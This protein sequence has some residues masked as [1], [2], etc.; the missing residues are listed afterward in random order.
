[1]DFERAVRCSQVYRFLSDCFRY[2][3]ED[4]LKDIELLKPIV[5]ELGFSFPD[6]DTQSWDT[7][8]LQ[9][10]HRRIF[11]L[12]G[13]LCYETEYGLPHEFRQSQE[14]A[15]ISGFYK[16]FGLKPGGK[17]RE[18]PDHLVVELE[19]MYLLCLKEALAHS[20]GNR[21]WV[22]VCSEAQCRFIN[23]HIGCWISLYSQAVEKNSIDAIYS[24]SLPKS[25]VKPVRLSPYPGL[26]RFASDFVAAHARLV[27]A[28][29]AVLTADR[30]RPTPL[31]LEM[32]CGGCAAH[33]EGL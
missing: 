11:G 16:A 10:E 23:D 31:G 26:A 25:G 15:D 28:A 17:L 5:T 7:P 2:P 3:E 33:G 24:Q 13:S 9:A 14:L 29:P 8:A 20:E 1:M 21:E 12:T 30:A 19:F 4:W 32:S 18:R 22:E 27:G 6:M